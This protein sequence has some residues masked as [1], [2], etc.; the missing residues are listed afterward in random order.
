ME[1]RRGSSEMGT[2]QDIWSGP[3]NACLQWEC[4]LVMLGTCGC[5]YGTSGC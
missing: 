2:L 3:G 5:G 4:V 1:M